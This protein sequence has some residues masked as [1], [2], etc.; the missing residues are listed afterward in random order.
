M[1]GKFAGQ[2]SLFRLWADGF[3]GVLQSLLC[4]PNPNSPANSE[5]AKLYSENRWAS[6][7]NC[8]YCS[9]QYACLKVNHM[10]LDAKPLFVLL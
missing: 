7:V 8:L 10:E 9:F 5:A 2:I 1:C 4:D 3:S 6:C